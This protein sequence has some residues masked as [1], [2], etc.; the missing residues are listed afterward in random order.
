MTVHQHPSGNDAVATD[1]QLWRPLARAVGGFD[2]DPAAGCEP[3][4]IA[5]D[6][7]TEAE[8]GLEQ[9]WEG[10]VWLNPPFSDKGRWY[11]EIVNQYPENSDRVVALA[12]C[13]AST[14]WFQRWFS[15]CDV[16]CMLEGR[17]HFLGD[18]SPNFSTM[19]GVW[20]PTLEAKKVLARKGVVLT[21]VSFV[22]QSTLTEMD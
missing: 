16:L 6:S 8:N 22:E 20:N 19:V 14:E 3:E 21:P 9:S 2:V 12:P 10:N 1:P 15:T 7:Y 11:R 18:G 4:A 5:T 13:D 17:K